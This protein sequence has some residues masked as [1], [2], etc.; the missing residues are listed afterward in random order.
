MN[1]ENQ[2]SEEK[3]RGWKDNAIA[4]YRRQEKP[5]DIVTAEVVKQSKNWYVLVRDRGG[6][7][8]VYRVLGDQ[9]ATLERVTR[10][11]DSL[12]AAHPR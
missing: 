2:P 7:A 9:L 8:A 3:Q 1:I 4:A 12:A 5:K 6:I 10:L 11:P